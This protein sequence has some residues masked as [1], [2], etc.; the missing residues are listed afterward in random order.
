MEVGGHMEAKEYLQQVGI[1][2]AKI[3]VVDG[4]IDKL[5]KDIGN[6]TDVSIRSAWPDGQPHGTKTTDPTGTTASRLA[7]KNNEKRKQL[8]KQLLEYEYEQ[9][10]LKSE[11]W[12][13]Q[14]EVVDMI[15][16]VHDPTLYRLLVYR[17][18]DGQSFEQIAVSIGYTWR[19]I[20]R[21]HGQ[22]LIEFQRVL[23]NK[24]YGRKHKMS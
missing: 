23:D 19:H 5:R 13:K 12:E 11:L 1:L 10:K 22:A 21:L 17:Y 9:M 8:R 24:K 14:M 15:G 7:D 2:K 4:M 6:M 20:I 18:V 16:H 3:S